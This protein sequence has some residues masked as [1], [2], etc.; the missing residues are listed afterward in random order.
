MCVIKFLECNIQIV[1][2]IPSFD[3]LSNIKYYYYLEYKLSIFYFKTHV[4]S[5]LQY[6][7]LLVGYKYI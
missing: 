2:K 7:Y 5:R 3:L 1:S 6:A 4:K